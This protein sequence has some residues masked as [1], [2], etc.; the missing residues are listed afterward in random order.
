MKQKTKDNKRIY[1]IDI[2]KFLAILAVLMDHTSGTLYDNH[3]I[4]TLSFFSVSLF[5]IILGITTYWSFENQTSSLVKKIKSKGWG[6]FRPYLVAMFIYSIAITG[7]FDLKT[8]VGNVIHFTIS[9][10]NYNPNV[11]GPFYY[12][13]LYLQLVLV[14]PILYE[15]LRVTKGKKF[16]WIAEI[17]FLCVIL[18]ISSFITNYTNILS[19]LGGGGKLFGGTYLVLVYIGMWFAKYY[20]IIQMKIIPSIIVFI[21]SLCMTIWWTKYIGIN[22]VS[23]DGLVPFG[24]GMNPPSISIST[25]AILIIILLFS[26]DQIRINIKCNALDFVVSKLAFLGKHT[27]YIFLYHML[28]FCVILI[29]IGANKIENFWCMR[30]VYFVCMIFGSMLIEFILESI[31]RFVVEAYRGVKN[32]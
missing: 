29:K 17:L 9:S 1:W 14:S 30:I 6:I 16:G 2:A 24:D 22:R 13:C 20:K 8:Y 25:Y 12:V 11:G 28:F 18:A 23:I 10:P 26:F 27:L 19:I 31:H 5:V 7:M 21:V 4:W 15:L 32:S 3:Y